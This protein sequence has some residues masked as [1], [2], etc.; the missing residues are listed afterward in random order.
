M[1]KRN[2][3]KSSRCAAFFWCRR[4]AEIFGRNQGESLSVFDTKFSFA[5]VRNGRF[6]FHR[7]RNRDRSFLFMLDLHEYT[8]YLGEICKP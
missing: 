4:F 2:H 1:D 8:V 5:G 6:P 3:R 7:N